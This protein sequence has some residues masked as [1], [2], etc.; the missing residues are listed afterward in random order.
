MQF[1]MGLSE[2]YDALTNQILDIYWCSI[3][4]V[5]VSLLDGFVKN[6]MPTKDVEYMINSCKAVLT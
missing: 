5:Q 3:R 1:L 4:Q 6:Q 2:G